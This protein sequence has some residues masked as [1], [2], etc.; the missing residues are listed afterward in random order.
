MIVLDVFLEVFENVEVVVEMIP[1]KLTIILDFPKGTADGCLLV[2]EDCLGG[3]SHHL[4]E[5]EEDGNKRSLG[6]I[7]ENTKG[8]G[9][10]MIVAV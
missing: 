10:D 2:R 5:A 1:C 9:D 7:I 6:L 4:K 3:P 8:K